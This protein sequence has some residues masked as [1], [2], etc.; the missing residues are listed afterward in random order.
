MKIT[1]AFAE[2]FSRNWAWASVH[3]EDEIAPDT[4]PTDIE[5]GRAGIYLSASH[6]GLI[7]GAR[8]QQF[9]KLTDL[10]MRACA[11]DESKTLAWSKK[12]FSGRDEETINLIN[13]ISSDVNVEI[14][15][16]GATVPVGGFQLL[17]ALAPNPLTSLPLRKPARHI[18]VALRVPGHLL[19]KLLLEVGI[20]SH[21]NPSHAAY[22]SQTDTTLTVTG[23]SNS[24]LLRIKRHFTSAIDAFVFRDNPLSHIHQLCSGR[25]PDD[26]E[27]II[28]V[29]NQDTGKG[30]PALIVSPDH[31]VGLGPGDARFISHGELVSSPDQY[32][33]SYEWGTVFGQ[34]VLD[35]AAVLGAESVTVSLPTS[36]PEQFVKAFRS[37][38][39][40]ASSSI[41]PENQTDQYSNIS[42]IH[43]DSKLSAD[44]MAKMPLPVVQSL[45]PALYEQQQPMRSRLR[46]SI[47]RLMPNAMPANE[48]RSQIHAWVQAGHFH[49]DELDWSGLSDALDFTGK[50]RIKKEG[51]L[52]LL[53]SLSRQPE[54]IHYSGEATRFKEIDGDLVDHYREILIKHVAFSANEFAQAIYGGADSIGQEFTQDGSLVAT[55]RS[56]AL[57]VNISSAAMPAGTPK[58][59]LNAVARQQWRP[60]KDATE[61][62]ALDHF[63]DVE[64]VVAHLR[65]GLRNNADGSPSFHVL[66]FQSDWAY[67]LRKYGSNK[68]SNI[69]VLRDDAALAS[70]NELEKLHKAIRVP[71]HSIQDKWQSS[72]TQRAM[73]SAYLQNDPSCKLTRELTTTEE[74]YIADWYNAFEN[75][76]LLEQKL[77]LA[78]TKG[79]PDG[80]WIGSAETWAKLAMKI[81]L[82]EAVSSGARSLSWD[83]GNTVAQRFNADFQKMSVLY[84]KIIPKAAQK[85]AK[86]LKQPVIVVDHQPGSWQIKITNEMANA[87]KNGQFAF[88]RDEAIWHRAPSSSDAKDGHA[89]IIK[90]EIAYLFGANAKHVFNLDVVAT[91]SRLP[92]A[93]K[94]LPLDTV[95]A[96]DANDDRTIIIADKV[97]PAGLRSLILHEVGVHAGLRKML[98]DQSDSILLSVRKLIEKKDEATLAA[99]S[100]VHPETPLGQIDEEVLAYLAMAKSSALSSPADQAISCIKAFAFEL[101]SNIQLAP[102]DIPLL[103]EGCLNRMRQ[104]NTSNVVTTSRAALLQMLNLH[105]SGS[106]PIN[107]PLK[108][109]TELSASVTSRNAAD[110][111]K[112]AP[113]R[114]LLGDF[115]FS[116]QTP[117]VQKALIKAGAIDLSEIDNVA[118]PTSGLQAFENLRRSIELQLNK[119]ERHLADQI[120][121]DTLALAGIS[122]LASGELQEILVFDLTPSNLGHYL[123]LGTAVNAGL[124]AIHSWVESRHD[125][126]FSDKGEFIVEGL[127]HFQLSLSHGHLYATKLANSDVTSSALLTLIE[128]AKIYAPLERLAIETGGAPKVHKALEQVKKITLFGTE[129]QMIL[130]PERFVHIDKEVEQLSSQQ[131]AARSIVKQY[132]T[133]VFA[134]DASAATA[135]AGLFDSENGVSHQRLAGV[136]QTFP[137]LI[138]LAN[139]EFAAVTRRASP[140]TAEIGW[141]VARFNADG[142][143]VC[144]YMHNTYDS[145]QKCISV[146]SDRTHHERLAVALPSSLAST[147]PAAEFMTHNLLN[148]I[149][150]QVEIN[151]IIQDQIYSYQLAGDLQSVHRLLKDNF[152]ILYDEAASLMEIEFSSEHLSDHLHKKSP[153]FSLEMS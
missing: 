59:L 103:A 11:P 24:Q 37:V 44:R 17:T 139:G 55:A 144:E 21:S 58:T 22:I 134:G 51:V 77:N 153:S 38:I 62:G 110:T 36:A 143:I 40:N 12:A 115:S 141:A 32:S 78:L 16:G 145:I 7:S 8:G 70:S 93:L 123:P 1:H 54:L 147:S 106:Q 2:Q 101:G 57:S 132:G 118:A 126:E 5:Q 151:P 99:L 109:K 83:D 43:L 75:K 96:Y 133:A 119:K 48:L 98:G 85:I 146:F 65:G 3:S 14:R 45:E 95:G 39:V 120:A 79:V 49:I 76:K 84:D 71:I 80:P 53:D 10:A 26:E 42:I 128:A 129:L 149:N 92:N 72:N 46:E 61:K 27:I 66:E 148:W 18:Q 111:A 104:L 35:T 33:Y 56:P 29:A 13:G 73:L 6:G 122:G 142:E 117:F 140:E 124:R 28:G 23:L 31:F 152:K 69:S 25:S 125:G 86:E 108:L 60:I 90:R 68:K 113:E 15:S 20:S 131:V 102:H 127:S 81:A 130:R 135:N 91:H 105:R 67:A 88:H 30:K 34:A 136:Q 89:A 94:H 114:I 63:P 52:R 47:E 19:S 112:I 87:V 97:H 82:Q 150:E 121:R 41:P 9:Q 137:L 100:R 138:P 50:T 64:R 74:S 4:L 107:V 116:E